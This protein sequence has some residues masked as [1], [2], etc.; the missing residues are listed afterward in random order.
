MPLPCLQKR[1]I[2]LTLLSG[3]SGALYAC[4]PGAANPSGIVD[5]GAAPFDAS[6]DA[7]VGA[8]SAVLTDGGADSG[9]DS[10]TDGGADSGT[11][12][13]ALTDGG[14]DSGTDSG[15][16]AGRT[17]EQDAGTTRVLCADAPC[18][19]GGTCTDGVDGFTC[20]CAAGYRGDT[21][22]DVVPRFV[23]FSGGGW[24]SHTSLAGWIAGLLD[25]SGADIET[26]FRNVKSIAANSGGGWFMSM[27]AYSQTFLRDLEVERDDYG[28]TGYLGEISAVFDGAFNEEPCVGWDVLLDSTV[29]GAMMG[30]LCNAYPSYRG[31]FGVYKLNRDEAGQVHLNWH[32]LVHQV[33]YAPLELEAEL[34]GLTLDSPHLPWA[35]DKSLL[36][37]ATI[38]T[39]EAMLAYDEEAYLYWGIYSS[40]R[41]S[42][43]FPVQE[44]V[45]PIVFTSLGEDDQSAQPALPVVPLSITHTETGLD[46]IHSPIGQV[47]TDGVSI[48]DAS[49]AS[50]A[51]LAFGASYGMLER[52]ADNALAEA[53]LMAPSW[54]MSGF[55]PPADI[56]DDRIEFRAEG[57]IFSSNG[58][59]GYQTLPSLA[60]RRT[61]RLGDGAY[62]DNAAVTALVKHIQENRHTDFELITFMNNTSPEVSLG[63]FEI[64]ESIR[65]LF[66]APEDL[67][68]PGVMNFCASP[69]YCLLTPSNHVFT[70][71]SW[72]RAEL[73]WSYEAEGI[74]L[75][76]FRV[77]VETQQNDTYSIDAGRKGTLHLFVHSTDRT[78]ALPTDQAQLEAYQDVYR[79][80]RTGVSTHGGAAHLQRAFGL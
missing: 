33:V 26:S 13:G 62:T 78:S 41:A 47:S 71:A 21:C 68:E 28:T 61:I 76:Y 30:Y 60:S 27:L 16:D 42:P 32:R 63:G 6:V 72:T 24:H 65:D 73:L 66:A 46:P 38:L 45:T 1:C 77:P 48:L 14:A 23:A 36:Y 25:A 59:V 34:S 49:I 40:L 69:G 15:T 37:A 53:G 50:S 2:R 51:A 19:N 58:E 11:D 52:L 64:P 74:R 20:T 7:G 70:P 5:A 67:P 54:F 43:S 12:G 10:G 75:K 4:V 79:V 17:D 56:V 22:G 55:A 57:R 39:D 31:H 9:T 18:E 80:T 3:L 8:D 29:A 44:G 35:S